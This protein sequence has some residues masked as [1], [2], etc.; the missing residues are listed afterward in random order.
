MGLVYLATSPSGKSYVG[1]TVKLRIID[2]WREHVSEAHGL[3]DYSRKLNKAIRKYGGSSFALMSLWRC[4]D[5]KDMDEWEVYFIELFETFGPK[6][7]N[8][9][10]GG[11][12]GPTHT[13][14]VRKKMSDSQ[15]INYY[16]GCPLPPYVYYV[17]A[18]EGEGFRVKAGGKFL[19]VMSSKLSMEEKYKEALRLKDAALSGQI[20]E[21]KDRK[22]VNEGPV[23]L[24]KY[25]SYNPKR[26]GYDARKPGYPRRSFTSQKLSQEEKLKQAKNYL[27]STERAVQ[28]PDDCGGAKK[29]P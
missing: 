14:E 17:K 5:A 26:K 2:R 16:E 25:I 12:P 10:R 8:L 21:S 4:D 18:P 23:K 29:P 22:R 9:T 1:Q 27:D 28:R 11:R 19:R 3:H 13:E 15:R 7:Y 6:G 24:P 20:D